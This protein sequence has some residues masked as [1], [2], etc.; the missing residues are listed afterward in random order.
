MAHK[1]LHFFKC[2][3]GSVES[4]LVLIPLLALFLISTQLVIAVQSRNMEKVHAQDGAS[5]GALT[6]TFTSDDSFI[7]INSS[8]PNQNLDMVITRKK[9]LLAQLV[10]GLSTLLGRSPAT[11][12]S[13]I[14]IIENQR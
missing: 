8:D 4:S 10:P 7:H 9:R 5:R 1:V 6:G 14:A 11:E 13:G 2:E 12:V 3:K